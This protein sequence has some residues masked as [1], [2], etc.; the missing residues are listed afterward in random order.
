MAA[1]VLKIVELKQ[2]LFPKLDL[3]YMSPLQLQLLVEIID[4]VKNHVPAKEKVISLM[5]LVK[6]F[7]LLIPV[8]SLY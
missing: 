8:Q 7:K 4:I 3:F 6:L 2:R 5:V 1:L